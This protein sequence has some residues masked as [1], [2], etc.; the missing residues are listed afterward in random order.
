M[1]KSA[2]LQRF[3][4]VVSFRQLRNTKDWGMVQLIK[5][6]PLP[7]EVNILELEPIHSVT[8]QTC[9]NRP[10]PQQHPESLRWPSDHTDTSQKGDLKNQ[11]PHVTARNNQRDPL[12]LEVLNLRYLH[13]ISQSSRNS[14]GQTLCVTLRDSQPLPMPGLPFVV[15]QR[16]KK[17]SLRAEQYK[18]I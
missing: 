2:L 7:Q 12:M 1:I 8:L 4:I 14:S 3:V 18:T 15:H 6:H 5:N 13:C 11:D 16:K 9:M 17:L 10:N